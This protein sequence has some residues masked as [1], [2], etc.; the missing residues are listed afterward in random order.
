MSFDVLVDTDLCVKFKSDKAF[1]VTYITSRHVV[2]ALP[3]GAVPLFLSSKTQDVFGV[4]TD[5]D[6]TAENPMKIIAKEQVLQDLYNRAAISDFHPVKALMVVCWN[7]IRY[8]L[9][10]YFLL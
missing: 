5:I 2:S 7:K 10:N 4:H 6:V 9:A 3:E 1:S 8:S